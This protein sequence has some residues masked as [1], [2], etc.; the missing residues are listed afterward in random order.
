MDRVGVVALPA[1]GAKEHGVRNFLFGAIAAVIVLPL[2]VF[3]YAALGFADVRSDV[4][5]GALEATVMRAAVHASVRRSA[6]RDTALSPATDSLVIAGGRRYMNDCI[7]C[8]GTPGKEPSKFGKS[9]YPP[10][11]Q[12]SDVGTE[13]TPRELM[14]IATHGIRMTG[15][16]P[17]ADYGVPSR[18]TLVAFIHAVHTLPP[19]LLDSINVE[20]KK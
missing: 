5:P 20:V 16:G 3:A 19:A 1:P 9:F 14:W 13:Y 8:H 2:L 4:P 7:G 10:A 17:K 18:G 15:M 6:S 12:F 11:P